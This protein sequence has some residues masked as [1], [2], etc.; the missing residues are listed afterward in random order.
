MLNW[1]KTVAAA[2]VLCGFALIGLGAGQA[3]GADAYAGCTR[4][5]KGD[6]SCVQ[7]SEYRVT[8]DQNGN[9]HM[10]NK[11]AQS[12]SSTSCFSSLFVRGVEKP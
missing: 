2:G 10:D 3:V 1:K 6:V 4:D 5:A 12:C 9:V 8:S 7:E 11:Q